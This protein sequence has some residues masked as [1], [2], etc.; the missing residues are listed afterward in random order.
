MRRDR[1]KVAEELVSSARE[2][3]ETTA[4]AAPAADP[5][6]APRPAAQPALAQAYGFPIP[7]EVEEAER[8]VQLAV[9]IPESL[10]WA[11]RMAGLMHGV[12]MQELVRQALEEKLDRLVG[13]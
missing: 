6:P 8:Q 12:E 2:H 10:R 1:A 13:G 5:D 3:A 11:V 9:R 4:Y 7:R